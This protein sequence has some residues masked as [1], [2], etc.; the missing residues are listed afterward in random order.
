MCGRSIRVP[1]LD[2]SVEP[3]PDPKLNLQDHGLASALDKLASLVTESPRELVSDAAPR[4]AEPIR[5]V[6]ATAPAPVALPEPIELQPVPIHVAAEAATGQAP[7]MDSILSRAAR[8]PLTSLA[9]LAMADGRNGTGRDRRERSTSLVPLGIG[10]LFLVGVAFAAGFGLGRRSS[11]AAPAPSAPAPQPAEN[12]AA[13]PIAS[14]PVVDPALAGR[15][16]YVDAAG[17]SRPD[18]GARV[19]VLPEERSGSAKLTAECFRSGA[20]A[21]DVQLAIASVRALDGDYAIAGSDGN[22]TIQLPQAGLYQLVIL[23][24]YQARPEGEPADAAAM[25]LLAMY[26]D[27]PP[28]VVGDSELHASQFRYRGSGTSPRDQ[29]FERR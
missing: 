23:S 29:T 8:D 19:L 21:A 14:Q 18:V 10:A 25:Q 28:Q 24:R 27:R 22:F 7:S 2:G 5:S 3:L 1:L 26:F 11:T 15:I 17:E 12:A 20:A 13:P 9:E 16:M 4:A 6:T